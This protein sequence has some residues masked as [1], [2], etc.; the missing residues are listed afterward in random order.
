MKLTIRQ[1]LES[2]AALPG[3]PSAL[4]RLGANEGIPA[5][6]SYWIAKVAR[7]AEAELKD[8]HAARIRLCEKH[9]T[10]PEGKNEFGFTPE[11]RAAFMAELAELQAT[12]I[13]LHGLNPITVDS[14]GSAV[15]PPAV[16]MHLDWLIVEE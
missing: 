5:R 2:T 7:K 13:D 6:S 15:I 14:L 9:G 3:Q 16:M 12:E 11:G 1:L 10:L 8:Y 4:A